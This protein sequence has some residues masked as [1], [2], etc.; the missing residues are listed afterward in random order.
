MQHG[1]HRP[2]PEGESPLFWNIRGRSHPSKAVSPVG[3]QRIYLAHNI[4]SFLEKPCL[5]RIVGV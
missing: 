1:P 4:A 2:D 3:T 5:M